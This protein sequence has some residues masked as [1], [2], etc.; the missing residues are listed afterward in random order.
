MVVA[1]GFESLLPDLKKLC[2]L[3]SLLQSGFQIYLLLDVIP[4][5][6]YLS[7]PQ[8]GSRKSSSVVAFQTLSVVMVV[9]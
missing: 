6:I 4:I 8:P 2:H 7:R 1:F 5:S 9:A 3:I